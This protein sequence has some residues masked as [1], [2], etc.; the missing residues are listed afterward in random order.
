MGSGGGQKEMTA[1]AKAREDGGWSRVVAVGEC[2]VIASA[3]SPSPTPTPVLSSPHRCQ[4]P[5]EGILYM[6][7]FSPHHLTLKSVLQCS[8][9]RRGN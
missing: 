9:Y 5:Q 2:D 7:G 4:F 6:P 8:F 1:T 3:W